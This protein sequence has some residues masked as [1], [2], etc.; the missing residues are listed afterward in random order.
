MRYT[1]IVGIV[2]TLGGAAYWLFIDDFLGT[3]DVKF[4]IHPTGFMIFSIGLQMIIVTLALRFYEFNPKMLEEKRRNLMLKLSRWIRRWGMFALTIFVFNILEFLPRGILTE[5]NPAVNYR[6]GN[7]P[8]LWTLLMVGIVVLM[9]EGIIRLI[10]LSKGYASIEFVFLALF[11]LGKKP[12]KKDPLNLQGN[13]REVEPIL[14]V[15]RE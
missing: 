1:L 8:L 12:I 2:L 9:W 6:A 13:F 4:H 14:F 11:K 3:L 15:S 7:L 10:C 5:I